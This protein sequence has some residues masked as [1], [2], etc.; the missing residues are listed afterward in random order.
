MG[1]ELVRARQ[2]IDKAQS[3]DLSIDY[4]E[5]LNIIRQSAAR[6]KAA[7]ES[8]RDIG[9]PAETQRELASA[10]ADID[11]LASANE[12]WLRQSAN[13]RAKVLKSTG[14]DPVPTPEQQR[15]NGLVPT[16]TALIRGPLNLWRPE[17]GAAWIAQQT[18][19]SNVLAQV[20]LSKQGQ[21]V[22]YE[23]LNFVDGKRSLPRFETR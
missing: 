16:R 10:I 11:S 23:A 2:L 20:P 22:P 15:L 5:A 12:M 18:G 9:T 14:P 4:R 17:D 7:V 1:R 19:D 6:E 3:P 8:I 13:A 21:Y